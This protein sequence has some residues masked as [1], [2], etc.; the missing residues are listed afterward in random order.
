LDFLEKCIKFVGKYQKRWKEFSS[1]KAY[2][3]GCIHNDY[4]THVAIM[5]HETTKEPR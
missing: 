1:T 4:D 3:D 2:V 5:H